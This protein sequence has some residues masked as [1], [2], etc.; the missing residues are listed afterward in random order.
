MVDYH[1]QSITCKK[2]MTFITP[3]NNIGMLQNGNT[4]FVS[5]KAFSSVLFYTNIHVDNIRLFVMENDTYLHI[6]G[7]YNLFPLMKLR[8]K[9]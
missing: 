6:C 3:C 2:D 5:E 9:T 1:I 7:L 4:F 8:S